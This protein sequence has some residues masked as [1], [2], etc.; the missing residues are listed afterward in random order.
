MNLC[1][2]SPKTDKLTVAAGVAAGGLLV[3]RETKG[4]AV[5]VFDMEDG[6]RTGVVVGELPGVSDAGVGVECGSRVAVLLKWLVVRV[7]RNPARQ[8]RGLLS[9]RVLQKRR[10]RL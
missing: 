4:S 2:P 1:I 3:R 9:W 7:P 6:T 10:R 8:M 5:A